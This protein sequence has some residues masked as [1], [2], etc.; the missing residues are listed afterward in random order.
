MNATPQT[1]LARVAAGDPT[2][3]R[4][5]IAEYGPLVWTVARRFSSTPAEAEDAVR[6]VFDTLWQRAGHHDPARTSEP[7]FIVMLARRCMIQRAR[8]ASRRPALRPMPEA[9]IDDASSSFG[10]CAEAAIAAE[11]LTAL[12][13]LQRRALSLAIGQGMTHAEVAELSAVPLTTVRS[14]VR[15]AIVAVRK[16]LLARTREVAP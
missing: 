12:D 14:L 7:A 5:S 8:R 4:Q 3:V 10:R 2:A 13:P 16:R 6:E 15:R 9:F 1:L 11:A